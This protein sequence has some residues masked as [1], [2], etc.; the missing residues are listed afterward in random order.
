MKRSTTWLVVG[1][2]VSLALNAAAVGAFVFH[3]FGP[4][5]PGLRL[6]RELRSQDRGA[7]R[8]LRRTMETGMDSLGQELDAARH[9][10]ALLLRRPDAEPEEVEPRLEEIARI[11]TEMNRVAFEYARQM[12]AKMSPEQRERMHRMFERHFAPPRRGRRMR[13]RG[14][15]W[16]REPG[17]RGKDGIPGRP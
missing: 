7:I 16:H 12:A 11:Q 5:P 15:P 14:Q 13:G 10:L 6:M 4:P 8:K 3:R 17:P 1:L 2:A 9:E